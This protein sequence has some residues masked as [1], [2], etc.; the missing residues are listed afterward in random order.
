M[1]RR[2]FPRK[3]LLITSQE[4]GPDSQSQVGLIHGLLS[5]DQ[6]PILQIGSPGT[7]PSHLVCGNKLDIIRDTSF[8]GTEDLYRDGI[9]HEVGGFGQ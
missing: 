8:G 7:H 9:W 5:W 6:S 3:S 2:A 1:L 4:E